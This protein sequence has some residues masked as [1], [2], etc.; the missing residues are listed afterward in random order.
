MKQAVFVAPFFQ[1]ATLQYLEAFARLPDCKVGV[2]TQDQAERLPEGLRDRVEVQQ[3][4]NCMDGELLAKGAKALA[5]RLGGLGVLVGALEQLQ[6]P[7]AEARELL[8]IPGLHREAALRFRDKD[9]MK[10]ALRAAGLPVAASTLAA[11]SQEAQKFAEKTGFPLVIKPP[12]G[13]GAKGTWRVNSFMELENALKS[14][15]PSAQNPAQLEEF[16][17]GEERTFET[18]CIEGRPVWWSGTR[19]FPG[20]LTVLENPWMQYCVVLPREEDA[21]FKAFQPIN[22]KA[23]QV[24]GQQT[25]LSHME[26]FL[27]AD[28]RAVISE[29][30]AR[31]PGVQIMPLMSHVF[32]VNLVQAW[33]ELMVHQRFTPLQRKWAAGV[34]FLRGH[35]SGSRIASIRGLAETQS[36]VGEWV[37]DRSLPRP[38]QRRNES[39]EGEGWVMV[40]H[41][42]TEGVVAA[43]KAIIEGIQIR[44]Q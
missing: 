40:R 37:A 23:L 20:P 1:P 30:G 22:Y 27:K 9:K 2:L 21:D 32:E 28:G 19:Y 42:T 17:T 36:R 41:T 3:L 29:V 14:A 44:Y 34:A 33:A 7:L 10:E 38:G 39:Y 6:V 25:G 26:W 11:S 8:G 31:P 12:A 15:R 18:I 5:S 13:L 35:G 4:K 16:I 43:L 24:L